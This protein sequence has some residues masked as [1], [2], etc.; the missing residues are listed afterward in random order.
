MTVF[1]Q[2]NFSESHEW[3]V[4]CFHYTAI[5][6]PDS[7]LKASTGCVSRTAGLT[8]F[9]EIKMHSSH[10]LVLWCRVVPGSGSLGRRC[11]YSCGFRRATGMPLEYWDI[12]KVAP[13][14]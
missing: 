7:V 6:Q 2:W 10:F 14:R 1:I 8:F 9:Q 4:D 3:Q 13:K 5:D 11:F 12:H